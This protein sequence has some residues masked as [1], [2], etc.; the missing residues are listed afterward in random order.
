M[1]DWHKGV[2]G[3]MCGALGILLAA[4]GCDVLGGACP[5]SGGVLAEGAGGDVADPTAGS[6]NPNNPCNF[7]KW[8]CQDRC[9]NYYPGAA[10]VTKL[11]QCLA[12]CDQEFDKCNWTSQPYD[13][14]VCQ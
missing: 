13:F 11:N 10:K 9:Q 14:E 3:M 7:K 6:C 4:P 8:A 2:V 1:K 12:C 5:E